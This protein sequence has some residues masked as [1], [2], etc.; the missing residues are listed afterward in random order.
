MKPKRCS[1]LREINNANHPNMKSKN[2]A[3]NRLYC[4]RPLISDAVMAQES[5]I[6]RRLDYSPD[7]DRVSEFFNTSFQMALV[8][9]LLVSLAICGWSVSGGSDSRSNSVAAARTKQ[10]AAASA[11]V[12]QAGAAATPRYRMQVPSASYTLKLSP[13]FF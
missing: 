10:A 12:V 5:A 7:T 4:D 6:S 9:C 11:K 8:A 3:S 2:S 13:K 1:T